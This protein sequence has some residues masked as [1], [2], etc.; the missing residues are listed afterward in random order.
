MLDHTAVKGI[1]TL[2]HPDKRLGMHSEMQAVNIID[3]LS[4]PLNHRSHETAQ[5]IRFITALDFPNPAVF[6]R[7][8]N[9]LGQVRGDAD[10]P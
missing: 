8:L 10:V 2:V 4:D 9:R 3:C 7:Q 5:S 6:Y 1:R